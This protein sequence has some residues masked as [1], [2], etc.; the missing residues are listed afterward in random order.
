MSELEIPDAAYTAGESVAVDF[1]AESDA[2]DVAS[3]ILRAGAALI[4]A[5]EL[6]RMADRIEADVAEA[7]RHL[8]P[9]ESDGGAHDAVS[10][11]RER[12]DELD[13]AA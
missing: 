11:L 1:V 3:D 12:A 7:R 9:D 5:A 10:A 2:I 4:V 13:G 8:G 6:R